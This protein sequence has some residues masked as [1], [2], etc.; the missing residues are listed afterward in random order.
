MGVARPSFRTH[1]RRFRLPDAAEDT[2]KH[3]AAEAAFE[4]DLQ[5]AE[6][7]RR[8]REM[9]AIDDN[10]AYILIKIKKAYNNFGAVFISS[11]R[12]KT[13]DSCDQVYQLKDKTIF[14]KKFS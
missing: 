10:D 8:A 12:E 9:S 3:T 14:E 13:L 4:A 6:G 2:E 11:H 7:V 5:A 1:L